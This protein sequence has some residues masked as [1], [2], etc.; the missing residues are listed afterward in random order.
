MARPKSGQ[1][2]RTKKVHAFLTEED[3]A[4]LGVFARKA[5]FRASGQLVCGIIERLIMGGMTPATFCK[6]GL[7]L[8]EYANKNGSPFEPQLYFGNRP[9]P[10]IPEA[11]ISDAQRKRELKAMMAE[12]AQMSTNTDK[13]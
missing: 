8:R 3:F 7:D 12:V 13:Q 1:D 5:G 6:V 11:T 2:V 10:V 4:S 9:A